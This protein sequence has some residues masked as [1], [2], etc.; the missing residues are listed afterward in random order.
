M[1]ESHFGLAEIPFR[2][3]PDPRF[4]WWSDQHKEAKDK[5][6]YH[7][8]QSVGPIYLIADIG[9]GKSTLARRISDELN[10]DGNKDVAYIFAPNLKTSNAFLRFVMDEFGVPTDRAYA[11]SLKSFENYLIEK[12]EQGVSPILLVDEAQNMS[13][14]M[15]LLIQHLFNFSTDTRFLV[16]IV[17]FAQPDI[18][19]KL[20][21]LE[22]LKSR[23]SVAK[24]QPFE[25]MQDVREMML[26]RW[27]TAGGH[28]ESFPF[29]DEAVAEIQRISMG[30]PRTIVKLSNESLIKA[31][32]DGVHHV[33]PQMVSVAAQEIS[34]DSLQ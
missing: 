22:A 3:T 8:A 20:N 17:L 5:I 15:L 29:S 24:L 34:V 2:V 31:A 13:R 32:V 33:D 12:Y 27:R 19:K 28:N 1:Y 30:L 6:M 9:T 18:Q 7:V 4:L 26:S 21:R 10:H 16:Q 14:D 23:L 11:R 25:T